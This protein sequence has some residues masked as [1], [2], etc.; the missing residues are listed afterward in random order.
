MADLS[1]LRVRCPCHTY[2][3]MRPDSV[4]PARRRGAAAVALAAAAF[5][6][7]TGEN[8]PVG[9]LQVMSAS[10]RTSLSATGLL[11]TI[12]ALVVVA[13][14]VPLTHLTR[15]VPRRFLLSGALAVFVAGS[16]ATAVAPDYGWLMAARVVM[17]LSHALFWSVVAVVAAGLFPPAERG[18]AIAGVM[19]G[20]TF[21]LLFGVPAGTW[22]G[23]HAGWRLSF[24]AVSFAAMATAAAVAVLI[25]TRRP[26]DNHAAAGTDPDALGYGLLVAVAVLA[27]AGTFTAY[28]YV[29][30]FL[31]RVSGL[32]SADIPLVLLLA[33]LRGTPLAGGLLATVALAA[34]LTETFAGP[35]IRRIGQR[36][37]NPDRHAVR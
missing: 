17:A 24:A 27:I 3:A 13:T 36:A 29:S 19:S 9:L 26:S 4:L 33:G 15:R 1:G 28:T 30:A 6:C 11:V 8:L 21:A 23:Q 32:P 34:L 5:C 22:I 2:A 35:A 37:R 12:Y 25:P 20:G 14:S 7:V 10:L 18:R 16:L 31:T